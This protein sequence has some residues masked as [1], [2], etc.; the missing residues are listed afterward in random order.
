MMLF[1]RKISCPGWI[2]RC[3]LMISITVTC[4]F[5]PGCAEGPLWRAGK[6]APWAQNQWAEEE[7]IADTLFVRKRRMSESVVAVI[8]APV[9]N[10]QRVAEELA[11]VLHR[12]P[13]LLLRLHAVKLLGE[14]NCPAAIQALEDA[15]RDHTSDI[16]IASIDAWGRMPAEKAIPQLQEIIGSDT[17]TDVRLAATRAL[18]NFSGQQAVEAISLALDDRN[19]AL[20]FRAAESLQKV[21][22]EQ[23]G[24]DISAWQRYVQN[25]IPDQPVNDPGSIKPSGRS[26]QREI[27]N[28]ADEK[29]DSLFR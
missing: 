6:Y 21:T 16:R 18:G 12:D 27:T 29:V 13:V 2:A 17:D 20:Q 7:K 15:S 28:T 11:E 1:K 22:G 14:L 24:R 5:L 4:V 23:Y 8:N 25:V 9:E 3:L 19:P 26:L 10:Q